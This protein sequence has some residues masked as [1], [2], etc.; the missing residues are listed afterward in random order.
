MSTKSMGISLIVIIVIVLGGY[1]IYS[2]MKTTTGSANGANTA[3]ASTTATQ[4]QGQDVKVGSG[5]QASP[6]AIVSVLYTGK[7]PDGT[8]FD[9]S[10]MHGNTPLKFTL[11]APGL[12]PGFQI[13]VNGM[14]EGGERLLAIPPTLGYGAQDVKDANG[15]VIIPANSTLVF[16]VQLVKV[17]AAPA[18]TTTPTKTQ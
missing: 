11:G 14:R 10:A 12:I 1:F 3:T 4:V 7:L 13:G 15:K 8:I 16:D 18:A 2:S 6:N 17:E 5:A 9:S